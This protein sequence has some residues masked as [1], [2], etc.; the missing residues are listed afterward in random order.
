MHK[1]NSWERLDL[2]LL[3]EVGVRV[4]QTV[5]MRKEKLG[6]GW[7]QGCSNLTCIKEIPG[8]NWSQSCS[9]CTCVKEKKM[10]EV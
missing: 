8:R 4:A 1:E 6:R 9:N 2:R 10:E 5:Y 7:S 3:Y